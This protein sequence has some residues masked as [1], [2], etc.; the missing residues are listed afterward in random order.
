MDVRTGAL[1]SMAQLGL[2][3]VSE[4]QHYREVDATPA[5]VRSGRVGRNE[6]CPCKSGKKFKKCC[7]KPRFPYAV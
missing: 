1:V 4:R 7:L 3:A 5:Q 6:L 2:M